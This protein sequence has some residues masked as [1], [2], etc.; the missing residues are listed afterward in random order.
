MQRFS[1]LKLLLILGLSVVITVMIAP[2]L[3]LVPARYQE[4]DVIPETIVIKDNVALVDPRSTELRRQQALAE[5]P[6]VFD[7]DPRLKAKS[8][9]T[10]AAAFGKMRE[11]RSGALQARA[12]GLRKF[13]QTALD[14][15]TTRVA[16]SEAG[17]DYAKTLQEKNNVL[18]E[19]GLWSDSADPAAGQSLQLE[20][21][22]FDL[23]AVEAR[24]EALESTQAQLRSRLSQL[25]DEDKR[26]EAAAAQS[27]L[28]EDQSRAK[29]KT[30]FEAVLGTT[31]AESTFRALQEGHFGPEAEQIVRGLL[32][33]V[34]D[35]K[36]IGSR[37]A[38][39]AR[40]RALQLRNLETSQSERFEALD[41]IVDVAEVRRSIAKAAQDFELPAGG[42]S[43]L[44]A[45]VVIAQRLVHPNLTENAGE[46][47][48]Q[49][50]DLL[51]TIAPVYFNLKKGE[52]VA[53]A[54]EMAT[55]QQV[56]VIRA[57]SAYNLE[58]PKYP[59]IAGTFL[60][61]LLTLALM[62][63]LIRQRAEPGDTRPARLLLMAL[64][65]LAPLV[66]AQVVLLEVPALTTV[67]SRIRPSTY[68][69]LIPAAL[70]SMLAGILL[71]FEVAIYLGFAT[72]LCLAVLLGNSLPVFLYAL[73]GSF[74]AAIPMRRFDTRYA[75]WQQGLRISAV[76]LPVVLVLTLL[77]Q[78][79]FAWPVLLDFAAALVNGLGVAFLTSTILPLVEKL[80][81]ITT[82]LRLL[83]LS[84]MNH[85][86]LKELAV[87][88]PG[89]YHHSIVVG[90][91]S[92]SAADGIR[93]NPLLV[94]VAS[95]YH[96]LGK[97]LCPL[98]FVE[99]Q[100]QKNFHDDL[101]AQTSA[102]IIVNHVRD[103][104]EIARRY[105]LGRAI[106]DIIAQHHGDSLVRFFYH[107]AQQD[108]VFHGDTVA[109][110][111]YRYP[112]PKPQT[113]EAGLVM[114]ADVTEAAIRSLDDP[115]PEEIRQMVQKL[116][117]RIYM[118]GQL[119]ESGLTF[120]DLNYVEKM[121]TKMLLSIHHHR[122]SYPELQSS[123]KRQEA[124]EDPD[125]RPA[126]RNILAGK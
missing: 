18:H 100:H 9:D 24:R 102:R 77:G 44:E 68:T 48:R 30:E 115:S 70:T 108:Q 19:I 53:R 95:Y 88:A 62:Y 42:L 64:L 51:K 124:L 29:L 112:G 73:M 26:L 38:L 93:A 32:L 90:N 47:E 3:N 105:K 45:L 28:G 120:N 89:T 54:G 14:R 57:L 125:S 4:G 17:E 2:N 119:D 99:N 33:P 91:L 27:G 81:D 85:P 109:E 126:D 31:V 94:R 59:Q 12:E 66:V 74:V 84:N 61:V 87:R 6:P 101:P 43:H 104:L 110:E 121:F 1:G 96:D 76:N 122:I 86:A 58:N 118:E 25:A 34:L 106:T 56:E 23:R 46:T 123:G 71:S 50:Q 13:R 22:R 11:V 36:I 35:L 83:E 7:Y 79:P 60:V 111:E 65:I 39:D 15:I 52:F 5:L 103:G 113:K 80:F 16:L 40:K 75:L 117:T 55:A 69:Y 49:R 10:L 82:S 78:E 107:K 98:Y 41:T 92:E 97:M 63:R 8:L 20:K 67:Y 72:S 114:V 116:A 37:E 21:L